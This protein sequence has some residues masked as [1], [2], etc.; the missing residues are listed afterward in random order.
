[1]D[2]EDPPAL[3]LLLLLLPQLPKSPNPPLLLPPQ[4][5]PNP[6]GHTEGIKVVNQTSLIIGIQTKQ[7]RKKNSPVDN[8]LTPVPSK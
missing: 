3:P 5:L 2:R 7:H 6:W 8:F 1:L 4:V